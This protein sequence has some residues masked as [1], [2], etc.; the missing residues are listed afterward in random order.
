MKKIAIL[1]I[2]AGVTTLASCTFTTKNCR[3]YEYIGSRWT[4]PRTTT[5][6]AGTPCSSL[7]T[8]TY[9]CNEMDDPILDPNDIAEDFKK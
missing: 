4:G 6:S 3:C 9:Q 2:I 1:L 5:A 7:N 8:K